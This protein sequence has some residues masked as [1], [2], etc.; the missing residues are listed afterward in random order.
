ML[1]VRPVM[2]IC[3]WLLLVLAGAMIFPALVDLGARN[4]DWAVFVL[5]AAVTAFIGGAMVLATRTSRMP[6][7]T[8]RQGFLLTTLAWLLLSLAGSFPLLFYGGGLGFADAFFETVS[9]LTTTGSTVMTG[10]ES[11][12]PGILIWRALLQ[13]VGGVG[14]VVMAMI[15]LPFLGVGGMQLFQTESSERSERV[16][17][18]AREL[19][20]HIVAIYF[21]LTFACFLTYRLLGMSAF[22]AVVHAMTTLSTGGYSTHDAS[23]GWFGSPAL[24]WAAVVFMLSGGIPFVA[25]I[26]AVNGQ[27]RAF[28]GDVQVR[29]FIAFLALASL[30][31][32]I[33]LM[34]L[35]TAGFEPALR[36]AAFHV[37]SIV[38]TTGYATEDYSLWHAFAVGMFFALTFIGGCTGSTAGGIKIYRHQILWL[39]VK[40]YARR[41]AR[42]HRV[43]RVTYGGRPV[44]REVE[45]S[46]LAFLAVYVGAFS[47]AAVLLTMLGLDLVT[48]LS[49][50]ATALG[51]VGPGL[52]DIVGPAGNFR[53]LPDLAKWILSGT[54]LLGRLELFTLLVLLDPGFWRN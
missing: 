3:G 44:D 40:S 15:M 49:A 33:W 53:D 30:V 14:I 6:P 32:A 46:V 22:D 27:W 20:S 34:A 38:T 7:L 9:G 12:P 42:P 21:A 10:L 23:F 26:R 19:V 25:Y 18:R 2:F 13:W 48:A 51:N 35:G 1:T 28:F 50:A 36:K 41:L 47:V 37:V 5:A 24:E 16:T 45:A 11:L 17:P 8:R 39:T 54:M 29:A 4:P 52:G 43:E 31:V